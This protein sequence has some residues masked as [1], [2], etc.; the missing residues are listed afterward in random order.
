MRKNLLTLAL[1][2]LVLALLVGLNLVFISE[3]RGDET[4]TNG[5]RS[6]Y[7][8]SPYGTLAYYLLL[9]ESGRTVTRWERPPIGISS[10]PLQP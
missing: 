4:E 5:D 8:G 6:S 1:I 10:A 2:G 7:K 9:E 3:P